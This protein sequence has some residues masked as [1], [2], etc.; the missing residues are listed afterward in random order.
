MIVSARVV[1]VSGVDADGTAL[2]SAVRYRISVESVGGQGECV[3]GDVPYRID[4]EYRVVP[5]RVGSPAVVNRSGGVLELVYV[6][7]DIAV[8]C[9]P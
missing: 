9:E 1:G 5:A 2:R 3:I 4:S 6:Q 7:D 8:G